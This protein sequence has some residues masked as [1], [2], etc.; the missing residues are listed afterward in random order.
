MLPLDASTP[1]D[2]NARN[3]RKLM[4]ILI[5]SERNL[6]MGRK[7]LTVDALASSLKLSYL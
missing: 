2:S 5:L 1:R 7:T 4:T 6:K 3:Y